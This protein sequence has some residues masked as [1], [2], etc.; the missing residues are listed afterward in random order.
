MTSKAHTHADLHSIFFCC[1]HPSRLLFTFCSYQQLIT[2]MSISYLIRNAHSLYSMH[3]SVLDSAVLAWSQKRAYRLHSEI[4]M[5]AQQQD[6]PRACEQGAGSMINA[7]NPCMRRPGA[8]Q[9]P[10]GA[11]VPPLLATAEAQAAICWLRLQ[12][13]ARP[14]WLSI[15]SSATIADNTPALSLA[16]FRTTCTESQ[17]KAV[18]IHHSAYYGVDQQQLS[19]S[20]TVALRRSI[21]KLCSSVRA[22]LMV[23]G[24]CARPVLRCDGLCAHR[25]A[26][27]VVFT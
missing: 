19:H 17:C 2:H 27:T 10:Q 16:C 7:G 12:D 5:H 8:I 4:T 13:V 20:D 22:S 11:S 3:L 23:L 18:Y 14:V 21:M 1:L 24:T 15:L 6:Y 25:A 9:S 26:W